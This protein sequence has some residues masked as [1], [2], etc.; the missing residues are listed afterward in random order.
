KEASRRSLSNSTEGYVAIADRTEGA[1]FSPTFPWGDNYNAGE[2]KNIKTFYMKPGD[3]FGFMLVPNGT[4]QEVFD[5]PKI[6]GAKLPLFS[7]ATAN[8]LD[9]FQVGQIADVTGDSKIFVMEDKRID[10]G[11]DKDY[12]DVV[13]RVTGAK[14]VTVKLDD[15]IAPDK[16]WRDTEVGENLKDYINTPPQFL[17]FNTNAVYQSGESINLIDAKVF[18]ENG[19]LDK[20]EL[21][22]LKDGN[23]IKHDIISQ[24]TVNENWATFKYSWKPTTPGNYQI[25]A[26]AY[27]KYGYNHP[28]ESHQ[29]DEFIKNIR[30][31]SPPEQLQFRID[32]NLYN[33][34]E[35]ISIT[36]AKVYEADGFG[37]LSKV[38]FW[39]KKDNGEWLP[40]NPIA[41]FSD[42]QQ[43]W[44]GF[45]YDLPKEVGNY[46]LKAVAYDKTN[47]VSNEVIQSFSVQK[48]PEPDVP[49]P[50]INTP[51]DSLQFNLQAAYN[52]GDTI[53]L[54][55]GKVYDANGWADIRNVH[56][57]VRKDDGQPTD[58]YVTNFQ[59]GEDN[60]WGI[61]NYSWNGLTAG[62]YYLEASASDGVNSSNIVSKSFSIITPPDVLPPVPINR[63]PESL[64]FSILPLYTNTEKISFSWGKVSDPD[65]A[66]DIDNVYFWLGTLDG[67]GF[68]V[69]DV[70]HGENPNFTYDR[71]DR[72]RFD[73]SVDLQS[74][75]LAPGRYQLWAIAQDKAGN[76]STPNSQNFS[77]ITEPGESE[78]SDEQRLAIANAANLENYDPEALAKT[79]QWVVWVTPDKYL[80]NLAEQWGI[81]DKG[82]TEY[83]PNTYIWEFPENITPDVAVNLLNSHSQEGVEFFYPLV[84][85]QLTPQFIPNDVL[86]PDQWHLRNIGQTGGTVGADANVTPAWDIPV[87][88]NPSQTVRGRGVVIGIV[89]DGVQYTHPELQANYRSD[90]SRDF[91]ETVGPNGIYS[92]REQPNFNYDFDAAPTYKTTIIKQFKQRIKDGRGDSDYFF[93]APLTGVLTDLNVGFNI[94]HPQVSE[95]D[96]WLRSPDNPVFDPLVT[97]GGTRNKRLPGGGEDGDIPP[98]ELFRNVGGNGA[99]FLNTILDDEANKSI[100]DVTADAPFS[101]SFYPKDKLA[102]FDR[103]Y[104]GGNWNLRIADNKFNGIGGQFNN[105]GMQL[106]TY[107]PHGTSV[108]GIAAA[109]GN[110]RMG[111]T[112]VSPDAGLAG[113]RLI[114]DEV[115][116]KQIADALSYKNQNIDIYNNSWKEEEAL[117]A[118]PQSLA[119]IKTG[120]TEGRQNKLGNIYVFAGGNNRWDGG[121]VNYNGFANS[122]YVIPVAAIDHN[123]EYTWYSEEGAP[124]LVSA[125]SSSVNKSDNQPAGVTTT[126][127]LG[128]QGFDPSDY[129]SRFSGTSS[130]APLVSGVVALMLEANPNLSWRDVQHILVNTAKKNDPNNEDWK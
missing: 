26:I 59:Q 42:L 17:Q 91:N 100:Q 11:S 113:L 21:F 78:L 46:Q 95:L 12:N 123:G 28:Q 37:D 70:R 67:K 103:L 69:G 114:A 126:D 23:E 7:L 18:D 88:G 35:Q 38:Q 105:W 20:V 8:P 53:N 82:A 130:A 76:Y 120:V 9:A 47:A 41:N 63:A 2:Y 62:N 86:F 30:V 5:N 27:D 10:T 97:T 13:F 108:A 34:G 74:K 50:V 75:N 73:F 36:D 4:V 72:A 32:R 29:S 127:M 109:S 121:N 6:G 93:D 65:G 43:N 31:N 33:A 102:N 115:T 51:P 1:K 54:T 79:R 92:Y 56:I 66:N 90:L 22:W 107:N 111:V 49:Q 129:T 39:L 104:A 83:I 101:G 106:D 48:T 57:T 77:I 44:G 89:D 61:F 40:S 60:N 125:Y 55:D 99:N 45:N 64:E 24:F 122:R 58:Y 87:P 119:A 124:L 71:P 84:P 96:A 3:K 25:K 112:G 128:N 116:D 19:D 68:G 16:D 15:V 98:I 80:P 110:N 85:T 81:V 94:A 118:S 117:S 52:Y 14:G